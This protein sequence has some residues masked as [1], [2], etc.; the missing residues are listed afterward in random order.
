MQLEECFPLVSYSGLGQSNLVLQDKHLA[1]DSPFWSGSGVRRDIFPKTK[2]EGQGIGRPEFRIA[3]A[4]TTSYFSTES[5][6]ALFFC[7]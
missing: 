7:N 4:H 2:Q 3:D 5:S 6:E 1:E